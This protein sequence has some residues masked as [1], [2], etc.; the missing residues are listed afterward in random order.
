[1][2]FGKWIDAALFARAYG[3]GIDV[4]LELAKSVP[5]TM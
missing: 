4:C 3:M 5:S 1:M 2:A